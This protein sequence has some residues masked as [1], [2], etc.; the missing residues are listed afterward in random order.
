MGKYPVMDVVLVISTR[1]ALSAEITSIMFLSPLNAST[2]AR[3]GSQKFEFL[4]LRTQL[5]E[6]Y[7][8]VKNISSTLASFK[9][10]V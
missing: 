4:Q 1:A 10:C 6:E 5:A 8:Q 2:P 7:E 3:F 9:V